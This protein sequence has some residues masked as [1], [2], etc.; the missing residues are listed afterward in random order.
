VANGQREANRRRI[1]V[2]DVGGRQVK[3]LATGR[4]EG[5]EI[6]SSPRMPPREDSRGGAARHGRVELAFVQRLAREHKQVEG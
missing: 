5:V 1:L 6:P 2:I 4:T 3:V